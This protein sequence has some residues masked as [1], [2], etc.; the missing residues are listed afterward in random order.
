M[1]N[2]TYQIETEGVVGP[3]RQGLGAVSKKELLLKIK[4]FHSAQYE[5]EGY[6]QIWSRKCGL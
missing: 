4:L 2:F 5:T 6:N 1:G 3:F